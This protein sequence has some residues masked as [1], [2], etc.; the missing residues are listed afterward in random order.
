MIGQHILYLGLS[1]IKKKEGGGRSLRG[2]L[3]NQECSSRSEGCFWSSFVSWVSF[4]TM[5][6]HKAGRGRGQSRLLQS[7]R[8]GIGTCGWQG[9]L[10][11]SVWQGARRGG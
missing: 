5:E 9:Q 11:S 7:V 2:C 8:Q 3:R 10:L 6:V 1:F 4:C